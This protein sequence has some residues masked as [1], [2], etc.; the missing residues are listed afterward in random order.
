M[1]LDPNRE[2]HLL[3][4]RHRSE[5]DAGDPI[6]AGKV[7]VT[8]GARGFT[9]KAHGGAF[10]SNWFIVTDYGAVGDGSTDDTGA[11][12]DTIDA[13]AAAGGGVVFFPPGHYIIGGALQDTGDFNAQI[14]FPEVDVST[15]PQVTIHILGALHPEFAI[16]GPFP[17]TTAYSIIES[18]LTGASGTAA[19]FSGGNGTYPV[20]NNVQVIVE[21]LICLAPDD[22]TFTFWNLSTCQ[23][24]GG[25][26]DVLVWMSDWAN[27]A[28]SPTHSNAYGVKLPQWSQ[29]NYT[30]VDGLMVACFYTGVMQGELA[31]CRGLIFGLNVVALEIPESKHASLIVDMHQ[32]GCT[33]GIRVTGTHAC[34]IL[35]FSTEHYTNP[36]LPAWQVTIYDLDDPSDELLGYI[37]WY[38]LDGVTVTPD[39][40]FN[41]NGGANVEHSEVGTPW[42]TSAAPTGAAGGDLSGT[43]PNPDVD[44]IQGVTISGTPSVGYVPTATSSSAATWQAPAGGVAGH[45]EVIVSG[46]APPVAVT[47]VAEDDWVYGFV[48]D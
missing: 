11:I 44:A 21:N 17:S 40:I 34:D 46:T 39:H 30:H 15:D 35:S 38:A 29:S 26:K 37:R 7:L 45:Y 20:Q 22:P 6:D 28:T 48:P 25:I 5:D 32:T 24:G 43:Y 27:P 16:H 1:P 2:T 41:V 33:Y 18:T 9:W 36:P 19:V 3:E 4:Q 10:T 42:S 13:C 47:N 12:Q 31:I 14:L 23:G 8:D